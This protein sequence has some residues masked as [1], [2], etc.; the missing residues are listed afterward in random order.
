MAGNLTLQKIIL[1]RKFPDFFFFFLKTN[2]DCSCFHFRSVAKMHLRKYESQTEKTLKA[3][4]GRRERENFWI[5]IPGQKRV[6]KKEKKNSC[7]LKSIPKGDKNKMGN[8]CQLSQ[9]N[10][11]LQKEEERQQGNFLQKD[12]LSKNCS[13]QNWICWL[14]NRNRYI[15]KLLAVII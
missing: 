13:M 15:L 4:K 10:N 2:I 8:F 6:F 12:F 3:K 11:C 7:G 14:L 5:K 9:K 1:W